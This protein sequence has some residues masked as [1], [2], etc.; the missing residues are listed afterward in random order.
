MSASQ[1]GTTVTLAQKVHH[2]RLG[3]DASC[4]N[5]AM[6]MPMWCNLRYQR[7]GNAHVVQA[8]HR[9]PSSTGTVSTGK[10]NMNAAK[11]Y[12]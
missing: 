2:Q 4:A 11:A 10:C 3:I 1:H 6:A 12:H 9:R 7:H 8:H 5:N